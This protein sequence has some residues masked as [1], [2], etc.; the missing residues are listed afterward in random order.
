MKNLPVKIICT[1]I[2]LLMLGV[3][4]TGVTG[5]KS[6]TANTPED[7][8]VV[9]TVTKDNQSKTYTMTQ[10]K[11]FTLLDG[12]AGTKNKKGVITGPMPYKGVAL[13]VLLKDAVGEFPNGASVRFTAADGYSK[14]L[15][16]D[17]ITQGTF[18]TYDLSGNAAEPGKTPIVFLA[19]ESDGMALDNETGPVQLAIMTCRERVTDG[20]NFIKMIEKVEVITTP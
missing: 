6:E 1:L 13:T 3:I 14:T 10:L 2:S 18:T 15:T 12:Y 17:Q 5:C 8:T 19:Y 7:T 20:S 4:M 9:V 16:Y 11:D